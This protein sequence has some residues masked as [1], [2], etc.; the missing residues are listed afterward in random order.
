MSTEEWHGDHERGLEGIE[1]R[2]GR[3]RGIGAI[4]ILVSVIL[5]DECVWILKGVETR[6][7][8]V[9]IT[10]KLAMVWP[11][12]VAMKKVQWGRYKMSG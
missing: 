5:F 11:K 10:V 1:I 2:E 6:I 4:G 7:Y 12:D 8:E 9:M 3:R